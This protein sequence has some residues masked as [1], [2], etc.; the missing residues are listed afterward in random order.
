MEEVVFVEQ[1]GQVLL[2][3]QV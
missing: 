1:D 3:A 2:P